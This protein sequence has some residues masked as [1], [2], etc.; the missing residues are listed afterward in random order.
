MELESYLLEKAYSYLARRDHSCF[1]LAQKLK[2]SANRSKQWHDVG[3]NLLETSIGQ[4]IAYL[5]DKHL[6]DDAKFARLWTESRLR[7]KPRGRFFIEQE[8]NR[9]GVEKSIRRQ[10]LDDVFAEPQVEMDLAMEL[11]RKKNSLISESD[12]KKRKEKILRYLLNKGFGYQ[13]AIQAFKE[14]DTKKNIC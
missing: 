6:L 14:F 13:I 10:V 9:K 5:Q 11:A 12:P 3:E 1:E 7:N 2:Q 8:L 4:I